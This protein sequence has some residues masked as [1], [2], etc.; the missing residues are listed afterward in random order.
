MPLFLF[1]VGTRFEFLLDSRSQVTQGWLADILE[2]ALVA[3]GTT[4]AMTR[5]IAAF[6]MSGR[7]IQ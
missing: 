4:L 1:L 2:P 7:S 5:D 6:A 3:V